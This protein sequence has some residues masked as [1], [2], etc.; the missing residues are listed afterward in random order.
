MS[1]RARPQ[2]AAA[3]FV[4]H[5]MPADFLETLGAKIR[6][7]DRAREEQAIAKTALHLSRKTLTQS[8]RRALA[9]ARR[10]DA[11]MRNTLRDDRI[12]FEAWE[13]ACRVP[14]AAPGTKKAK[15]E[16]KQTQAKSTAEPQAGVQE[17][18]GPEAAPEFA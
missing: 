14:R 8:L 4:K 12:A 5:A 10:M 15:A 11:I 13:A 6:K 1:T 16:E 17:E 18:S 2:A 3:V 7:L 9:A